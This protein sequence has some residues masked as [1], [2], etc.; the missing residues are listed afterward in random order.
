MKYKPFLSVIVLLFLLA[1]CEERPIRDSFRPVLPELPAHWQEMLGEAH[2]RL[3]WVNGDG[4]WSTHEVK[5]GMDAPDLNLVNEWI[6]AVVAWPFWPERNL[7][8]GLMR[9]CG[10]IFP[11][12]VSGSEIRLSWKGGIDAILWKEL[13]QAASLLDNER[14]SPWNYDWPRFR[15]T[16][17]QGNINE[18]V[19]Q[20]PWLANWSDIAQRTVQSGFDSRRLLPRKHSLLIISD[21]GGRWIGSSPFATPVDA[22][23]EGPLELKVYDSTETWVSTDG[24]LKCSTEGWLFLAR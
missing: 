9:P 18:E 20:D 23:E 21:L 11:W 13:G 10:A 17:I 2:W 16:L 1:A 14:R 24:I 6:S 12:D 4:S 22:P 19:K 7:F 15:E 8:P 3:E 5:P